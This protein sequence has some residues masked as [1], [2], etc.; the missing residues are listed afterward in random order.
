MTV[1]K[2]SYTSGHFEL[3]ID[4]HATTT[5]LKSV[6]GGHIKS[7][8]VDEP[9]GPHNMRV[10]HASTVD[11][12]P[13]SLELGMGGSGDMIEWIR[14]SWKKQYERRNGQ[15]THANFDLLPTFEHEFRRAL[16]TETTFPTLDGGSKDPAYMKVKLQPEVVLQRKVNRTD[17]LKAQA[18]TKQKAWSPANFLFTIDGIDETRYTNKVES[19]TVKQGIKKHYNGEDRFP[20]IEPTKIEFPHITFTISLEYCDKLLQWHEQA[21]KKG[22]R[23][24]RAQKTGSIEY[25]AP[26]LKDTLFL[27]NLYEVGIFSWQVLQSTANADPIKRAKVELY[28]GRMEIDPAQ[29]GFGG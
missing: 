21:V 29:K 14:K 12:E 8:P 4:G 19:F 6:D 20:H 25:L 9:I 5:Y 26:N 24:F 22:Q 7:N 15:V 23:D 18:N 27:I 10:K 28:V 3:A 13:F 1:Q 11:I 16:I 2:R 17:R